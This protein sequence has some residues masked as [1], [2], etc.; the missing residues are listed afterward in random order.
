MS[1]LPWN[2]KFNTDSFLADWL[3]GDFGF[4]KDLNRLPAVNIKDDET[5][6][7]LELAAPGKSKADFNVEVENNYL[8]IS[9]ESSEEHESKNENYTRKEYSY[10][11]FK[12]S[13]RL[14]ENVNE[15][16]ISAQYEEGILKIRIPKSKAELRNTRSIQVG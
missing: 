13:F 5:G 11:S 1:I 14:P 2:T 9:S 16:E 4:T 8:T 6:F 3:G 12:R 10:D 7:S 15:N